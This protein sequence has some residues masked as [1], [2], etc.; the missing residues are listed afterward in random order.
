MQ[1]KNLNIVL[2][3]AMISQENGLAGW[4]YDFINHFPRRNKTWQ[5]ADWWDVIR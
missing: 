3:F 5:R 2:V 4:Y 1:E